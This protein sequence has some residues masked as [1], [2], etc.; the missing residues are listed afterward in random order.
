MRNRYH[1]LSIILLAM[2]LSGCDQQTSSSQ[3]P[4]AAQGYNSSYDYI[5]LSWTIP[6][7]RTDGSHLPLSDLAGYRIYMG[8]TANNLNPL[9]DLNDETITQ[10]TVDNLSSSGSYYFA[11]TAYDT[12]GMES[13]LSQVIHKQAS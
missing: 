3:N 11:V 9:V 6:T 10:Y 8:T 4:P 7:T 5:D 2:I 12:D 13:S 1:L